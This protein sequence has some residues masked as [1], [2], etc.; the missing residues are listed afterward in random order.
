MATEL[1]RLIRKE[2]SLGLIR[3]PAPREDF[4]GNTIAPMMDVPT[5]DVTFSYLEDTG[6][7]GLAPARAEDAESKLFQRDDYLAGE[8]RASLIDWALKNRYSASEVSRFRQD[9]ILKEKL[10]GS[11][12]LG[13]AP[14]T[15]ETNVSK[16]QSMLTRDALERRRRLDARLERLAIEPLVT[17]GI[18]YNDGDL[19]WSVDFGRPADQ[20]DKATASGLWDFESNPDFD[21]IGDLL[22]VAEAHYDKYGVELKRGIISKKKINQWYRSTKFRQLGLFQAGLVNPAQ[23]DID[24]NY[25]GGGV[26]PQAA[27]NYIQ[28]QT[29]ITFETYDA[30]IRTRPFG[31]PKSAAQMVRFMPEDRVILMPDAQGLAEFDSTE[32]GFAKMLTSPHPEGNWQ[33]GFY[34]WEQEMS[35][36][37]MFVRG[38]GIK[39]FPVFPYLQYTHTLKV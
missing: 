5:D 7:T 39:A 8:G 28:E 3:E 22:K 13:G 16:F 9:L 38:T 25:L 4:I 27:I 35:D 6:A 37:W 29:G 11:D 2:T 26:T 34:E 23:T 19:K 1:E 14:S 21:V 32:I 20:T 10:V 36:P 30:A 12:P 15:L 17:G 31:Q 33:T 18:A 24:L